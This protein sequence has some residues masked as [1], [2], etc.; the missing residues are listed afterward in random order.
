MTGNKYL[1]YVQEYQMPDGSIRYVVAEWDETK[2]LYKT[3]AGIRP[4]YR[5]SVFNAFPTLCEVDEKTGN[6][7]FNFE[8]YARQEVALKRA[9]YLWGRQ[10]NASTRGTHT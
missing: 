3:P 10:V 2:S 6:L 7:N 4:I 8:N 1:N 5:G 9:R